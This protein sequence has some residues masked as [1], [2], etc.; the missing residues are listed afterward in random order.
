MT[1]KVP[2]PVGA[3]EVPGL[4][5]RRYAGDQD[6]P[7]LVEVFD[8]VSTEDDLEWVV[9]VD[10]LRKEYDNTPNFEPRE[11]VVIADVDGQ[12]VG[13]CQVRWFQEVDGPFATAH[14]ERVLPEWRGRGVARTLLA[15]NTVRARELAR[16]HAKGPWKMGT[17]AAAS[18][19]HRLALLENSGYRRERWYLDLLRDLSLPIEVRPL[20]EG[21]E[22]RPVDEGDQ[23]RVFTAMWEAFRGSY[24]FREMTEKD[25]T[26]FCVSSEYQPELWVVGWDGDVVAGIVMCWIDEEE[27]SRFGR[28]WG[29]NDAVAVTTDYRRKGL[30]KALVSCSLLKLREMGMDYASLGAD[31]QNPA[32]AMG[33]YKSMGYAVRKEFIDLTRPMD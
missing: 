11:D 31:T 7:A 6:L 18:E 8:A 2:I 20:P 30:A 9:T 1:D 21:I 4:T 23:K 15:V 10:R 29:Y 32:D 3:P 12:T 14:R 28:R 5:L 13:Y 16:V 26:G 33:L 27:N 22:V 25:W 17:V 24:A 19:E